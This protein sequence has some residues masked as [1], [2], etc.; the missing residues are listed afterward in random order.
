MQMPQ[1]RVTFETSM[2][3]ADARGRLERPDTYKD[4]RNEF[5]VV[6]VAGMPMMGMGG[7][8]IGAGKDGKKAEPMTPEQQQERQA[9]LQERVKDATSIA[10]G[11]NVYRPEDIRMSR[12]ASGSVML[13]AFSRKE[14]ELGGDEKTLQFKTIMGPMELNVKF[15]LKDMVYQGKVS[16]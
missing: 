16:L 13:F 12:T 3:L 2:P 5:V 4:L 15:S 11:K 10:I 7:G 8:R 14:I 6:S 1:V 9:Q